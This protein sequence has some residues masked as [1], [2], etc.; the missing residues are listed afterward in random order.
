MGGE[1]GADTGLRDG[2]TTLGCVMRR[3]AENSVWETHFSSLCLGE[4]QMRVNKFLGA[5]CL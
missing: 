2:V 4:M 1:M 3:Q 5:H